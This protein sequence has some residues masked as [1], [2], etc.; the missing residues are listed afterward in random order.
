MTSVQSSHRNAEKVVDLLVDHGPLT[1]WEI[2][3]YLEWPL[4]RVEA[5]IKYARDELCPDLELAIPSPTPSDG[6]R[7]QVTTEWEL[8]EAGA[9]HQLGHVESRLR[10]I[11]RD[12]Q[13]IL[14]RTAKGSREWRRAN[15]L[16]KHLSHLLGTLKE[17]NDG[18][19]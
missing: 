8:V 2:A 9:S 10:S 15:F 3:R 6:W 16:N 18:E 14:P 12:V 1:K 13:I 7:Y 5:A 19:G 11:H 17:I 4:G